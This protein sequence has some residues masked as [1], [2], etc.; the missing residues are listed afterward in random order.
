MMCGRRPCVFVLPRMGGGGDRYRREVETETAYKRSG[1]TEFKLACRDGQT[2]AVRRLLG[3]SEKS[4][5]D[6]LSAA[7]AA[8]AAGAAGAAG[9][10]V[11]AAEGER[12]NNNNNDDDNNNN[13]NKN[14]NKN[15]SSNNNNVKLTVV[16]SPEEIMN[17]L[18]IACACV[19]PACVGVL[20]E[21]IETGAKQGVVVFV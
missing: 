4:R 14:N 3:A 21:R 9:A 7:S 19:Q 5:A 16:L 1:D 17:G 12:H 13:K 10:S 6:A 2:S 18:C 11:S 20:L 15:N 8:A